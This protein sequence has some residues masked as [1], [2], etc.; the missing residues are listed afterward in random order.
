[1]ENFYID[2]IS[3]DPRFLSTKRIADMDLL[4]P[5]TRE[6]VQ[7]VMDA[8]AK[9]GIKLMVFETFR[10]QA[11]QT[12]LFNQ[13]AST[14]K[15]VGVHHYG[16]ACDL[17]KDVGGEPNWKG[18]FD[19][20]GVL[21]HQTSLI[22]GGDWGDPT[23]KHTFIDADHVQRV[24]IQRQKALFAGTWYPDGNYDPYRDH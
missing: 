11:R 14:L 18:S 8:S 24:T 21:A 10:S 7:S 23:V 13:G 15:E 20:L 6:L 9:A 16:L 22:W 4:E 12:E 19:F 2:M 17:V 3:K 1:V 5:K